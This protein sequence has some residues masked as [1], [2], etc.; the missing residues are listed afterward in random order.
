MLTLNGV[1]RKLGDS[2]MSF[3]V[4]LRFVLALPPLPSKT[5]TD[6]KYEDLNS[7]SR[8]RERVT[9]P[10]EE[11]RTKSPEPEPK[12]INDKVS[13]VSSSEALTVQTDAPAL[14]SSTVAE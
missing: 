7:W 13:A 11:S 3:T 2:L 12:R 6:R 1:E 14:F 5:I 4:T 8:A 9:T 10:V